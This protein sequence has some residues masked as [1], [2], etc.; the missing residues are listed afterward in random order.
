MISTLIYLIFEGIK[1]I[2]KTP[3][4]AFVSILMMT[5]SISLLVFGYFTF[6][7]LEKYTNELKKS[8][9][10]EVFF[11]LNLDS[12][13]CQDSFN[14]IYSLPFIKSGNF[15]SKKEAEKIFESEFGQNINNIFE[16]NP[17]PCSGKYDVVD[18]YKNIEGLADVKY[19][20]SILPD[21]EDVHFPS[22]FV[23]KFDNISS[24]LFVSLFV[25][26]IFFIMISILV[27]SNT[28]RLIV[29]TRKSQMDLLVLLGA[30]DY[31]IRF[32]LMLEGVF[33]GILSGILSGGLTILFKHLLV[34]LFYPIVDLKF[35]QN[36]ILIIWCIIFGFILGIVGS[37]IG[38]TRH[39]ESK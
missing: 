7:N 1:G 27:V 10:I 13:Q 12:L 26:A 29:M 33:Q 20:I 5:I 31:F 35:I 38:V 39:L 18:S 11:E 25:V 15:V 34:Y 4:Q 16:V 17:L 6:S 24:K 32:P 22:N 37:F 23:M 36:P 28:I 8:Y 14:K 19:D 30:P 3:L 21:V 2:L 9:Q